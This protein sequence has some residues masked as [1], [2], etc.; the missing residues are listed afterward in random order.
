MIFFS[1]ILLVSVIFGLCCSR[2]KLREKPNDYEVNTAKQYV[3]TFLNI[4]NESQNLTRQ[5]EFDTHRKIQCKNL[6]LSRYKLDIGNKFPI[7]WYLQ[8]KCKNSE[9]T[10]SLP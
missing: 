10:F 9:N 2:K 6:F 4:P 5:S 1:S 8:F 7:Y 3:Q